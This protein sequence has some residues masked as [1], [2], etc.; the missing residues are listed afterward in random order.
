MA[1][2]VDNQVVEPYGMISDGKAYVQYEV[3]RDNINDRFYWDPNENI[4]LYTLPN[5]F[6]SASSLDGL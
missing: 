5:S 4:L 6:L 3:I 1:V 2:I